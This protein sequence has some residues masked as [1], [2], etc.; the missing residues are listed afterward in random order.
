MPRSCLNLEP[1]DG[2]T[3]QLDMNR[4]KATIY[5]CAERSKDKE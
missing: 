5:I 1:G 3:V 2:W 4:W